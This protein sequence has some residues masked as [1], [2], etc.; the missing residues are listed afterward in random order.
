MSHAVTNRK[1]G[2]TLTRHFAGEVR[3]AVEA[4]E[5]A[6]PARIPLKRR[7][8]FV[9]FV[10]AHRRSVYANHSREAF[11]VSGTERIAVVSYAYVFS[12]ERLLYRRRRM[13]RET[14]FFR[15]RG[16]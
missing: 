10:N 12:R 9:S 2:V 8:G 11:R 3:E 5:R 16:A 13:K 6:L 7:G 1:L 14:R 4:V 15:V